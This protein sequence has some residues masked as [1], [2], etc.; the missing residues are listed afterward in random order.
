MAAF[1]KESYALTLICVNCTKATEGATSKYSGDF[2]PTLE[3]LHTYWL[4]DL[5]AI[6]LEDLLLAPL[7]DFM[8]FY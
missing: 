2:S 1:E 8:Y 7:H 4:V 5:C 6:T 3:D